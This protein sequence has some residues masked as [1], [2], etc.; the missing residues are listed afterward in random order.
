MSILSVYHFAYRHPAGRWATPTYYAVSAPTQR[1]AERW[2]EAEFEWDGLYGPPVVI[3]SP[4][5]GKPVERVAIHHPPRD[6]AAAGGVPGGSGPC[7]DLHD[8]GFTGEITAE[9]RERAELC[10]KCGARDENAHTCGSSIEATP[11]MAEA[12]AWLD[13][14]IAAAVWPCPEC[15]ANGD[16]GPDGPGCGTIHPARG[17]AGAYHGGV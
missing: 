3:D 9:L 5:R 4:P 8:F 1:D 13:A 17:F 14:R 15:G 11:A 12:L 2:M 6:H 16:G 7:G 10:P